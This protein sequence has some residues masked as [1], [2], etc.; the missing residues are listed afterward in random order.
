MHA[1]TNSFAPRFLLVFVLLATCH[2]PAAAQLIVAHRGASHDAPENTLAAFRL[3]WQQGADGI[4][5]DFALTRDGRIVCI[6]DADTKRIAGKNLVVASSTLAELKQL[7]VGK[8]KHAKY[9]GERIPTIEEVI[10]TIPADKKFFIELKVGPEIVAPLKDVLAQSSLNPEQ[11]IVISFHRDTLVACEKHLPRIAAHWLSKYKQNAASGLWGPIP[12]NVIS[13]IKEL[14]AE[15]FGSEANSKVFDAAYI[16]HLRRAGISTFHVWTVDDAPTARF[17][18]QQGAFSITTN[19][20]KKLRE[21]LT[22]AR[23]GEVAP[24]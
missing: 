21:A 5:G 8:W 6:H 2:A 16:D 22:E 24:E 12:E 3:A 17:Y 10:E 13:T 20:P 7:D 4:E 23:A 15:G 18:Q 14:R 9:A 1:M 11:A 19:R